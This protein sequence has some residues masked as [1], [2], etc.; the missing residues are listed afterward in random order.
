MRATLADRLLGFPVEDIFRFDQSLY[1]RLESAHKRQDRNP[2][3][4]RSE[5]K[6]YVE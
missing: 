5:A 2:A 4:I 6:P 1:K 3:G